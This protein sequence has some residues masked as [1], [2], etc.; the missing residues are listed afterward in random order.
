MSLSSP[1]VVSTPAGT[2]VVAPMGTATCADR[3][4]PFTF[5]V[6]PVGDPGYSGVGARQCAGRKRAD[7]EEK[8]EEAKKVVS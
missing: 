4:R 8:E 5:P 6:A 7:L 1:D 3:I 2:I